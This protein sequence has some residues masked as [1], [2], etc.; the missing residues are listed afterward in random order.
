MQAG[1]LALVL[2]LG[3]AYLLARWIADPLQSLIRSSQAIS[4]SGMPRAGPSAME[5]ALRAD[6][7]QARGPREVRELSAAFHAM[8]KRVMA[9][10]R[11]QKEFVANVSHELKTPLTAIQGF[12]QALL[13][14]TAATEDSRRQAAEV[15]QREAARMLRMATDLLELARLESGALA[16]RQEKVDMTQLLARLRERYEPV[17]ET[18]GIRFDTQVAG[19]LGPVIGDE[20]RLAQA[21]G[22]IIENAIKFTPKGGRVGLRTEGLAG[23]IRIIVSDTGPGIP[24]ADQGRIFDRFYQAESSRGGGAGQGAG[25]GL[26]IAREVVEGHSG[27]IHVRSTPGHGAEFSVHLPQRAGSRATRGTD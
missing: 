15:I 21:L 2:A 24:E 27:R 26:A 22:N 8:L 14:G 25:L 4:A 1:M 18:A 23:E 11:S 16:M 13:D 12:S 6:A 19:R 20:E 7:A 17:A 5:I 9:S 10:Q 3:L